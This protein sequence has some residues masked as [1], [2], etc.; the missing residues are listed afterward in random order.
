MTNHP[1]TVFPHI[2]KRVPALELFSCGLHGEF[3]NAHVRAPIVPDRHVTLHNISRGLVGEKGDEVVFDGFVIRAGH[4]RDGGQKHRAP[5]CVASGDLVRVE[6]Q[7]RVVPEVK[8]ASDVVFRHN[9]WG[10]GCCLGHERRVVVG[11]LPRPVFPH[12]HK[13]VS[14]PGRFPRATKGE[15]VNA[16]VL[17]PRTV[18]TYQHVPGQDVARRL[19]LQKDFKIVPNAVKVQALAIR[20]RG[21]KVAVFGIP[22]CD[23]GGIFGF[24]RVVPELKQVSYRFLVEWWGWLSGRITTAAVCSVVAVVVMVWGIIVTMKHCVGRI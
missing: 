7:E 16:G 9:G 15:F 5:F 18:P 22:R 11:N 19:L 10:R 14:A 2:D 20:K 8:Q 12:V 21:Q 3:V 17:G 1:L 4:V 13:R 23:R 6:G 24:E